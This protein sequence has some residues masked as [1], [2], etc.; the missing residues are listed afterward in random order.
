MDV[1]RMSNEEVKAG[2]DALR[3][4]RLDAQLGVFRG[5]ESAHWRPADRIQAAADAYALT[6]GLPR[7]AAHPLAARHLDGGRFG[8]VDLAESIMAARTGR[9]VERVGDGLQSVIMA[10]STAEFPSVVVETLRGIAAARQ[11]DALTDL[12][13]LTADLVLPTY[14][15]QSYSMVDLE[16]L[17]APSAHEMEN[18]HFASVRLTGETI[19]LHSV[20][21][22]I[23]ITR[24]AL[25][26][27]DRGF[28]QAAISAFT[29]AAHRNEMGLLTGLVEANAN[30]GDGAA[31]FGASNTVVASLDATGLGLAYA[32]LRGQPTEGGDPADA[33]PAALLVHADDE[34]AALGLMESL[35][36]DRRCR[37]VATARLTNADTWYVFARPDIYPVIGRV[38]LTGAD[39]SAVSFSGLESAVARDR[40]GTIRE[41]PGVALPATHSVGYSVL[42]R[43]GAVA[44]P[45]A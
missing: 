30:L 36:A 6:M 1:S 27:D 11:S 31:L 3:A 22:R 16:G 33:A 9:P 43:I 7:P 34:R 21:A 14:N 44:C 20:F 4:E 39:P 15:S 17:P 32:K 38:R 24:Q 18:Y 29:A 41:Y 19:Q 37:V 45:K 13:A 23:L 2:L 5:P 42:S 8:L 10:L 35:P 12:Q 25:A 40:D 28:I 26:N